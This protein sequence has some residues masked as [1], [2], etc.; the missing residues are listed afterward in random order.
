[1]VG[2]ISENFSPFWLSVPI[3]IFLVKSLKR[4]R[5]CSSWR[6][7]LAHNLLCLWAIGQNS[8]PSSEIELMPG[9]VSTEGSELP[10]F[11]E[12]KKTNSVTVLNRVSV[13]GKEL[14]VD[15]SEVHLQ[16]ASRSLG[17]PAHELHLIKNLWWQS[18]ESQYFLTHVSL[19]HTL[20][21]PNHWH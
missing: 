12:K 15:T 18:H 1:M 5:N 17:A 16:S 10:W 6:W 7:W 13:K 8:N 3:M 20:H 14:L 9:A 11:K 2:H 4:D 19:C 21:R